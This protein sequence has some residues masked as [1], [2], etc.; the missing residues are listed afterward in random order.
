MTPVN[1][2]EVARPT[3]GVVYD[4]GASDIITMSENQ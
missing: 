3:D 1:Q 2:E 4:A